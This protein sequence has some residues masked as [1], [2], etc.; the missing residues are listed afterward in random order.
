LKDRPI[1]GGRQ[2]NKQRI[3]TNQRKST[4]S[5]LVVVDNSKGSTGREHQTEE[6]Y[7]QRYRSG[8]HGYEDL[9][10]DSRKPNNTLDYDVQL[11]SRRREHE[12]F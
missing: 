7:E 9:D 3:H 8:N 4:H 5:P 10:V 11:N 1:R 6:S 12:D 2:E